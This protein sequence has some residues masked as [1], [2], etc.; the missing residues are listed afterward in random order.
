MTRRNQLRLIFH[1]ALVLMLSMIVEAPGLWYAFHHG[2]DDLVRFY[3]KQA[4]SV[5]MATGIWM[6]ATGMTLPLLELTER[7]ITWL[8]W[9]LVFT[10]Y[11]FAL[12]VGVFI[13]ELMRH[14]LIPQDY[15]TQTSQLGT[16]PWFI[17]L[18]NISCLAATGTTSLIAG[19]L[20][21]R[22]AYMAMHDSP[23]D[24]IH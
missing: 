3:L 18:L 24:E 22:G 13:V 21:V 10:A 15:P 5:L 11:T 19:F 17:Q 7:G 1:G 9:S 20:I 12:A 4:H 14:P 16:M 8:A 23:I 2:T 6:I